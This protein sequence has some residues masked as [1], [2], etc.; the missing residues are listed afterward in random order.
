HPSLEPILERTLGVPLFQ[1]QLL[2]M[3]MA[4][5]GFTAGEAEEL[6]R[7]MGFKRSMQRMHAIEQRLRD[8]MTA[9]GITGAVQD[10]IVQSITSFALYGFPECVGGETRVIDADT[11]RAVAIEDI[12]TGRVPVVTRLACDADLRL[13]PRRVTRAIASGRKM[14]YRL[15]T[16][17]GRQIT[18]TAE[19]PFLT[20][21]GWRT[22]G[23]LS[24]GDHVAAARSL[25][26]LG[27][28]QWRRHELIVLAGLIAEGNLCHPGTFYFYTTDVQH[29]DEFVDAVERFDNT[30]ATIRRHRNCCSVHVR[31]RDPS[32]PIGAVEWVRRLGMWGLD[33]HTRRLPDA[34]F[35][36]DGACLGL[37]LARLWDGDGHVSNAGHASYDTASRRLADD[38][39]HVLLRLGI[40]WRVYEMMAA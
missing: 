9:R 10:E 15:R 36:L 24:A 3:A 7:A 18:A 29:R 6:R 11:G 40:V 20:V 1:E 14:V 37:L 12:A 21:T 19:H 38:V 23:E 32:R 5:A 39:Q 2:R 22:L 25:P 17:L 27:R 34:A 8:G 31:R 4:V 33:S 16:S 28:T 35:E 26:S 13:Q 30:R